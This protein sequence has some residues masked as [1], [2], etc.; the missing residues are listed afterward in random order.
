MNWDYY[1][2]GIDGPNTSNV[3]LSA[4][5]KKVWIVGA[6]LKISYVGW[7]ED[8]KGKISVSNGFK[9]ANTNIGENLEKI[10]I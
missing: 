1:W 7:F 9:G 6:F 4:Y 3:S 8:I 10:S 5:Y 2:L